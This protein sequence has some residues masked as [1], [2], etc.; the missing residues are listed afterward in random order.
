V[1]ARK[2]PIDARTA[3]D[4]PSRQDAFDLLIVQL[5]GATLPRIADEMETR[6]GIP[7]P[8]FTQFVKN[9]RAFK[10]REHLDPIHPYLFEI[11]KVVPHFVLLALFGL[12]RYNHDLGGLPIYPYL[13]QLAFDLALDWR[14]SAFW[15][16]PLLVG[17]ALSL[18]AYFLEIYRHRWR[19]RA[20]ARPRSTLESDLSSLFHKETRTATPAIRIGRGWHP[21]KYRRAGWILRAVG[22]VLLVTVLLRIEPPSFAIFIFV[23]GLVVVLLLAEA[24]AIFLPLLVSRFSSWIE[25]RATAG[26]KPG[27]FTRF[28]QPLNLVATRPVSLLWLSIRYHFQPSVPTG[29]VLAMTQAI[30]FY[31]G[32]AAVFFFVGGYMFRQGL[33]VWFQETYRLQ[34]DLSL[35]AG[36]FLFWIT[37][38]LFRF[39]LFILVVAA[40]SFLARHPFRFL[41]ALA[42]LTSLGLQ[43]FD[44]ATVPPPGLMP[45]VTV[46][47]VALGLALIAFEPEALAWLKRLP[48]AR[49]RAAR[50]A[51]RQQHA[52]DQ[53]RQDPNRAFGVV[54]M[55]GDD[56]S[57]HKLNASLLMDRLHTLR[58]QLDSPGLRLLSTLHNL[59][60]DATLAASFQRLHQLETQHD[61]TL[62]HPGQLTLDGQP[63][64]FSPNLGLNLVV[65]DRA[66][67]DRLLDAWHIRRWLVTMLSTAGH[68]QDT[69]INLV[70]IALR[71]AADG[72]A[73]QTV[74][75]L[76]QNKYDNND[77]NRPSQLPYHQG[78]LGHR[79]KLARLLMAV[80][81]GSRA[82]NLNDWTPF[83]FKAGGLV[84]MDLVHEESLKLTNMLVLDR[85][86]NAHDLDAVLADL[87]TA[88]ANP[89]VVIVIPGRTTTNTLTPIGQASQLIEEGQRAM[90]RGVMLLGGVGAESLGTG[91]GNI[92]AIQ[93]GRVQA[94]LCD[95]NTPLAPL[96]IPARR[97]AAFQEQVEGLVG[98]GPHAVGISEDLWGVTQAAHNAIA[99]GDPVRFHQSQTLW[100]KVR[101]SWSHAEWFS[102]FPRWA[103]GYLQ[104]LL[105]PVMQRIHDEGPLS[106]FAKEIRANGGRFF[107]SAPAALLSILLMPVAIIADVSPFVQ[108]IILLWILGFL[109]NQILTALGLVACLESTGFQ[110]GTAAAGTAFAASLAFSLPGWTPFAPALLVLGCLIGG[111]AMGLGRWLYHRGRDIILFGPQLVIHALGQIVRQSLEFV[112]SG[113]SANDARAVNI[114]FRAWAGPRE[115][116][117]A[118]GY[119]NWVN[120]RTVV[121]GVGLLSFSLNLFALA[122]LD[123]LNVLLLLPSLLFSVSTLVGPF[124]LQPKPGRHLGRFVWIPKLLGW[125]SGFSFYALVAWFIAREGWLP[126]IGLCLVLLTFGLILRVGLKY[127]GYPTRLRRLTRLLAQRIAAAHVPVP[128]AG[129]LANRIVR[130]LGAD[131]EKTRNTLAQAG[132]SPSEID[133]TVQWV[134]QRLRPILQRPVQEL[135]KP[136]GASTRFASEF[137]RSLVLALFTFL[138][139][140]IVP[141][142]GLLVFIAPDFVAPDNYRVTL[143]LGTLLLLAGSIL[144]VVLAGWCCSLLLGWI[145]TRG[146]TRRG[147]VPRIQAQ[148]HRFQSLARAPGHMNPLQIA[149]LHALFTDL[150]THVDQ[151]SYAYARHTLARIQQALDLT[152]IPNPPNPAKS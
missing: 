145:E 124:L 97:G 28:I 48:F 104:M 15:A 133:D 74:F 61:V 112:L 78:E 141:V 3:F 25:D 42:A 18:T 79:E 90:T 87:K 64:L 147:L 146:L 107:L 45:F 35:V 5:P 4:A 11:A 51:A 76:I 71:L 67:R 86:A 80:A 2:E 19:P 83:G 152:S 58:D 17:A 128:E 52:L 20:P 59:P 120:L 103:G 119:A 60:N 114:P 72:L 95:P 135:R 108:I 129:A 31:L 70:D 130:A 81:P 150:Q 40:A 27:F 57:F 137:C 75:Y 148:Y 116:R 101:E 16:L 36:S 8:H 26:P 38:Y 63:A 102:A 77:N 14:G 89:G 140:C 73:P 106:V 115:D 92:Q 34:R 94:A 84:A 39:G 93:Y 105:D 143:P 121:W 127:F 113:A 7:R 10:E 123:F 21:M 139:F 1:R 98:F 12:V 66:E 6:L 54:Y 99:L 33:E 132:L 56:L 29:G 62:W 9:F 126:W 23:K 144:A 22:L 88:L 117:P 82:Y 91:W 100:H 149:S 50:R 37:M 96:T 136:P 68:A 24:A 41:G 142:P 111:Y 65:S 118:E 134:Q 85:N 53:R 13:K 69:G 49:R 44:P 138:W 55:S 131:P 46:P 110:R 43:W 30:L 151:R 122:Q 109:M 47:L 32:F 125:F